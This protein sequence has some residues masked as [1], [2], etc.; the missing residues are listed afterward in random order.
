MRKTG[1]IV[2]RIVM[3]SSSLSGPGGQVVSEVA[4]VIMRE[5]VE[6]EDRH[7]NV[8]DDLYHARH[9]CMLA[10]AW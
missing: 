2:R 9:S 7:V 5:E 6:E 10:L 3:W 8:N 4:R 1:R